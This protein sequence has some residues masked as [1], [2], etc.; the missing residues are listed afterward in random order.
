MPWYSSMPVHCGGVML[1]GSSW[2]C[3][4]ARLHPRVTVLWMLE[5]LVVQQSQVLWAHQAPLHSFL[6]P[7]QPS[8]VSSSQAG[9][10]LIF[11]ALLCS[12]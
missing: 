1:P 4:R 2:G 12:L 8:M 6:L 11:P 7:C 9:I 5:V 3:G 10:C